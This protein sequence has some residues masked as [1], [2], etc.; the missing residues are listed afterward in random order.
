MLVNNSNLTTIWV[1]ENNQKIHIWSKL[2]K[3]LK[4][5]KMAKNCKNG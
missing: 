3:G 5:I 4:W 1:E 2:E